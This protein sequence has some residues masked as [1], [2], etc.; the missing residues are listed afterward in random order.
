MVVPASVADHP[1]IYHLLTAV[2]QGPS[3]GEFRASLEDPHYQPH[4][5]LLVKRGPQI[6][7]HA[8]VTRRVMEFGPIELPV[9]GLDWL[10]TLPTLRGQGHGRRLLVAA[11][12]HMASTGALAGLVWTRIP[13]FFRRTGWALCGRHFHSR[14]GARDVISGLIARGLLRRSHRRLNI[15]P[16]RRLELGALVRIY[17]QNLDAAFGPFQRTEA[18]W[19][20]LIHRGGYD[21]ICVALDGPDLLELEEVHAP[22]VGY[23]VTRGERIVELLSAPGC[24]TAAAQLMARACRDAIERGRHTVSLDAPPNSRVDKLFRA[25]S[26]K[27]HH[28]QMDPSL[29]LMVKLLSP[30]KLLRA[31]AGEL[32]RRAEEAQLARPLELGLLVDGKKYRLA[33]HRDRVEAVGRNIGRSYLRLNVADFTRLVLGHF[34]W[35]EALADGRVEPSTNLALEAGR[36][37]FPPLPLWL[38]PLDNLPARE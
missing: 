18:Y 25:A 33:I 5:R 37:L 31:L 14:G 34:D 11:E 16:W 12:E 2:F 20:W 19:K 38:P 13:H 28:H 17:K 35:D 4:D 1:G 22:I 30:V 27:R 23:S 36:V 7:A 32:H 21:Q 6:I 9:A 29:V 15:R 3:R 24:P 10:G 26:G 8:L